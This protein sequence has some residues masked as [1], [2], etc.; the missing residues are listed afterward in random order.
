MVLLPACASVPLQSPAA[1][2]ALKVSRIVH[3]GSEG[4]WSGSAV[5]VRSERLA[6]DSYL[7]AFLTARHV[8]GHD[9]DAR[10]WVQFYEGPDYQFHSEMVEV[11]M[12][13]RHPVLDVGLLVVEMSRPVEP[14]PIDWRRPVP[15][16]RIL[17][18][19]FAYG[20]ALGMSEGHVGSKIELW[21]SPQWDSYM[22]S[23]FA[24]PGCSG[25]AVL[26]RDGGLIGVQVAGYNYSEHMGL[27]VPV[28]LFRDWFESRVGV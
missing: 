12:R 7:V 14:V 13:D 10:I 8:V 26:D 4:K 21:D 1:E 17:T 24:G 2:A 19:G 20:A 6:A 27:F 11:V 25:G 18:A 23:S 15:G 9:N 22:S 3:N 5:P 28:I 16:E